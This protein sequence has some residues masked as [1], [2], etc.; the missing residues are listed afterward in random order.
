LTVPAK[1][2]VVR[3]KVP[4]VAIVF[5]SCVRR[6]RPSRP[7][8]RSQGRSARRRTRSRAEASAEDGGGTGILLRDAKRALRAAEN[9]GPAPLR[10]SRAR[11]QPASPMRH[12]GEAVWTRTVCRKMEAEPRTPPMRGAAAPAPVRLDLDQ[13]NAWRV[14][15]QRQDHRSRTACSLQ[16]I[17][18]SGRWSAS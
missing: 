5:V 3:V 14:A 11:R 2:S 12:R 15:L 1:P 13:V 6:P 4:M 9:G 17:A 18:G 7:R 8:W 16:V 10:L